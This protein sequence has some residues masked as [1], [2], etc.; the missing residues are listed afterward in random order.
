M[1]IKLNGKRLY[2]NDSMKYLRVKINSKLNSKSHV[3]TI[4]IRLTQY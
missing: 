2:P 1:E 3:N 4:A